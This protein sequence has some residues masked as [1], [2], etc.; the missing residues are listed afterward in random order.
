M[1]EKEIQKAQERLNAAL[2][3]AKQQPD[4][5]INMI[6][7]MQKWVE[8]TL[9]NDCPEFYG[10]VITY[11]EVVADLRLRQRKFVEAES[12]YKQMIQY[13]QKLY[14]MDKEKYDLR[15]GTAYAKLANNCR[16]CIGCHTFS[17]QPRPLNEKTQKPYDAGINFY[18]MA[19]TVTQENAKKGSGKHL[20]LRAECIGS[21]AVMNASIGNYGESI[22][23]FKDVIN[24]QKALY[25]AVDNKDM[26]V[27][28][29]TSMSTLATVYSLYKDAESAQENLEDSIYVLGEHEKE[30]PVRSGIL[31]ARDY[32]NL[33]GCYVIL[34]NPQED[35]DSAYDKAT[36]KISMVNAIAK[37]AAAMDEI[38]CYMLSGQYYKQIGVEEKGLKQL[39]HAYDMAKEAM[40][41]MPQNKQLEGMKKRLETLLGIQTEEA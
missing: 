18:K 32:M 34:K 16:T 33:A 29:G 19:I 31:I 6:L 24:I 13:A 37:N 27:K 30:D 23:M 41:K 35:I 9:P 1:Y 22:K 25:Q 38:T 15:L 3:L 2:T 36:Q 17:N 21:M 14:E 5:A 40:E 10:V 39:N 26:G 20:E 12:Y 7:D 28:L 8:E 11:N 4:E